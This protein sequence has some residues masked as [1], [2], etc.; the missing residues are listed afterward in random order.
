MKHS[1][2][3]T[4]RRQARRGRATRRAASL[5]IAVTLLLGLVLAGCREAPGNFE[6]KRAYDQIEHLLSFGPRIAGSEAGTKA[7]DYIIEQLERNGWQVEEQTFVYQGKRLRNIV[8]KRGEGPLL[9]LGTHYDTR[10]LADRDE[11]DRSQPVPGADDGGSGTAVLLELARVM[12][13][14]PTMNNEVWLVF[15]DGEDSGDID[16]WDW[17]VGS[18]YFVNNL[19]GMIEARPEYV[20]VVDMVGDDDQTIY[21]E[22]SSILWLQERIW[23]L[24]DD[25][26]YGDHFI[27]EHR[28]QIYDD[29]TPFLNAGLNAALIIDFDYPYWHTGEDTLDKISVDSLQ[30]VGDVLERLLKAGLPAGNSAGGAAPTPG[31]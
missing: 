16:G 29:Q 8:G 19:S 4:G 31:D 5:A 30:R 12:G 20:L 3:A 10:P 15:F 25:L 14:V 18:Q 28:Y 1:A 13:A 24:A 27:A 17:C 26:G 22:W 6:G 21:Y 7:G 9:I 23:T 2:A 11:S